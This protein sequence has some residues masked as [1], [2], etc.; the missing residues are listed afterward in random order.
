MAF[1]IEETEFLSSLLQASFGILAKIRHNSK[2]Q[3]YIFIP[4][5]S[6]FRIQ[7]IVSKIQIPGMEYKHL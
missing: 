4:A 7:E 6:R 2:Q 1:S 3:P 5:K